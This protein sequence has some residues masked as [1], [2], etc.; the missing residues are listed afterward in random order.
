MKIFIMNI[1]VV[2]TKNN[3]IIYKWLNIYVKSVPNNIPLSL[4]III[5]II[6]WSR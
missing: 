4:Y 6:I 3:K 1:S 2:P 5:I